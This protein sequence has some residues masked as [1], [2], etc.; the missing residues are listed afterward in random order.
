M[1][2]TLNLGEPRSVWAVMRVLRT[3]LGKSLCLPF[4]VLRAQQEPAGSTCKAAFVDSTYLPQM[5]NNIVPPLLQN[6]ASLNGPPMSV[7]T[8][9]AVHFD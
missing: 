7:G 6:A 5:A 9:L 1:R 2:H 4:K 3:A 8:P